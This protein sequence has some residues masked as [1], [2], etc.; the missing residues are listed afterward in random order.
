MLSMPS[1]VEGEFLDDALP[2]SHA[3]TEPG[4]IEWALDPGPRFGSVA[5][6]YQ[7]NED[8]VQNNT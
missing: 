1:G 2:A 5:E 3:Q 7:G 8:R 4:A 6:T